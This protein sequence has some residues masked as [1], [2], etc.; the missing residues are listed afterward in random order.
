MIEVKI[1]DV[2]F[3]LTKSGNLINNTHKSCTNCNTIFEYTNKT[4]YL[5]TKCNS[6]RLRLY[7]NRDKTI[8]NTEIT[9]NTYIIEGITFNKNREGLLF[10]GSHRQC[11]NCR[12]IFE[13]TSKN[14][15]ICKECNNKRIKSSSIESK[16]FFRAKSRA[17]KAG[18]SFNICKDD[19]L[20]PEKCPILDI[21]LIKFEGKSGGKKNSPSLDRINPNL[22]YIKGNIMVISFLANQMKS[23]A[24]IAELIKFSK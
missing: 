24:N 9:N 19:V 6:I 1:E 11:T 12:K 8:A 4:S 20:I 2:K 7:R 10:C 17:K 16:M 15:S 3:N 18:I 21:P 22:G 5:C 23:H 13:K 14:M